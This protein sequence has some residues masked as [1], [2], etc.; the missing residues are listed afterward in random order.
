MPDGVTPYVYALPPPPHDDQPR[1]RGRV[2]RWLGVPGSVLLLLALFLPAVEVCGDPMIPLAFPPVI[3][4]YLFGGAAIGA[5]LAMSPRALRAWGIV[6]RVFGALTLALVGYVAHAGAFEGN[7]PLVVAIA[8]F[9]LAVV[10]FA[11][12][13]RGDRPAEQRVARAIAIPAFAC[14]VWFGLFLFEE[15]ALWGIT[16]S[17]VASIL[18]LAGAIWWELDVRAEAARVARDPMPRAIAR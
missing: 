15:D 16:V 5:Y 2:H 12:T 11:L 4:P 3:P 18:V 7:T 14:V 9:W 8:A 13:L 1:A 6:V 10:Q 17:F